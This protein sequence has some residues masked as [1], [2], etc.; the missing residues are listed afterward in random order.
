V[1]AVRRPQPTEEELRHAWRHCRRPTW[2]ETFEEAM[3][4]ELLSRLVRLNAMHPPRANRKPLDTRPHVHVAA[5]APRPRIQP[6]AT[7]RP[8]QP[9]LFDRKRAAAGEREDD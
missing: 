1:S 4:D 7:L 6:A 2:P 3:A 9:G 8:G 5:P